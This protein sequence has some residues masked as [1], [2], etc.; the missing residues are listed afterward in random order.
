MREALG[1][2]RD[3]NIVSKLRH[4]SG[5]RLSIVGNRRPYFN[6]YVQRS[7]AFI[8]ALNFAP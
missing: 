8:E 6:D 3:G 1:N 4:E 2:R 5:D 7:L